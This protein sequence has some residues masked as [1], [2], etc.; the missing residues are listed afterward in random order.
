[1]SSGRQE[2]RERDPWRNALD[3]TSTLLVKSGLIGRSE[4]ALTSSLSEQMDPMASMSSS[5]AQIDTPGLLEIAFLDGSVG[6]YSIPNTS[7]AMKLNPSPEG[8]GA[9]SDDPLHVVTRNQLVNMI[10]PL[11][12]N[13]LLAHFQPFS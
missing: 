6:L 11:A 9:Q 2:K 12:S 3:V 10:D 8:L 1:M 13:C 7:H 4:A 5:S